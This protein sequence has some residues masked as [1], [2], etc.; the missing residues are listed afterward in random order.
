MTRV[1]PRSGK[2]KSRLRSL[3]RIFERINEPASAR[4]LGWMTTFDE[5]GRLSLYTDAQLDLPGHDGRAS[6]RAGLG[7]SGVTCSARPAPWPAAET[8]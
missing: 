1:L 7:R 4:Y 5:I 8:R 3:E 2:S 6:A